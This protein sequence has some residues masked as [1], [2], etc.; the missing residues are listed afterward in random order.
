MKMFF[1]QEFFLK[2]FISLLD[3]FSIF[4]IISGILTIILKNTVIS[5]F[6]LISLFGSIS[7]YLNIIGFNFIALSYLIVYIGAIS[8]LFL[9]ILMLIDIR[10]S[11]LYNELKNNNL[12][13]IIIISIFIYLVL[14]PLLPL[15]LINI[16]INN[17]HSIKLNNFYV[18]S[19][20]WDGNI[21]EMNHIKSIGSILYTYFNIWLILTSFILLLAMTGAIVITI[22]K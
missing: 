22:K 1:I 16:N 14:L 12:L 8:I 15:E 17:I 2:E 13:L 9:F 5:V 18:I 6:F 10:I 4:A 3:V 21:I 20:L 7:C 19:N 11:E